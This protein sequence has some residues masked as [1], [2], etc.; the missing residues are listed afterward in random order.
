M[1]RLAPRHRDEVIHTPTS[2]IDTEVDYDDDDAD[3][4]AH[5]AMSLPRVSDR[6][7]PRF[8]EERVS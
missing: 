7:S 3:V 4:A 5:I 8:N 2:I 6:Y 1:P